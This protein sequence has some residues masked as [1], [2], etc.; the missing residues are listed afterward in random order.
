MAILWVLFIIVVSGFSIYLATFG[1]VWTLA[2]FLVFVAGYI[3]HIPENLKRRRAL[4]R[5][6]LRPDASLSEQFA[7]VAHQGKIHK[8][9]AERLWLALAHAYQIPPMKLRGTDGLLDELRGIMEHPFYDAVED[10]SLLWRTVVQE[11]RILK[12]RTWAEF[13]LEVREIEIA[14]A[15]LATREVRR[16]DGR[17]YQL[18]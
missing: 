13:I 18:A 3:P 7:I 5:L 12:P 11:K 8:Q 2:I 17:Q 9:D 1:G 16:N 14:S 15:Q 6:M 4:K 10:S